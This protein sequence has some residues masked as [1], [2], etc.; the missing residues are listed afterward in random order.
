M[1][2]DDSA[3][4]IIKLFFLLSMTIFA[5]L[6]KCLLD[7]IAALL[8][9]GNVSHSIKQVFTVI[10]LQTLFVFVCFFEWMRCVLVLIALLGDKSSLISSVK[11]LIGTGLLL[12]LLCNEM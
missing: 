2:L 3:L 8:L 5:F 4:K 11:I 6:A 7:G 10:R 9:T 1:Q 12:L